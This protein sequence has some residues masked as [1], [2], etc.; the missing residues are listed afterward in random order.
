[1]QL[2]GDQ[3]GW[4]VPALDYELG[5]LL[6]PCSAPPG[7]QPGNRVLARFWRFRERITLLAADAEVWLAEQAGMNF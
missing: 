5:Y 3:P 4:V 7:W 2:L 1:M 6:E